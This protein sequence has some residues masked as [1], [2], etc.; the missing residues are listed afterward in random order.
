[1]L[2]FGYAFVDLQKSC[3]KCL[4]RSV[5]KIFEKLFEML[6][7]MRF[8]AGFEMGQKAFIKYFEGILGIFWGFFGKF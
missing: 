1:M 3:K 8:E 2:D 7:E 6:F 4:P 5:C